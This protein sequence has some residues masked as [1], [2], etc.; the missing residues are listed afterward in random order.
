LRSYRS[1]F[2]PIEG[3]TQTSGRFLFYRRRMLAHN[4]DA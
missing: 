4:A 3:R 2:M 1:G